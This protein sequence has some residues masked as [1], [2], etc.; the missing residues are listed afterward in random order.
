MLIRT[1]SAEV[2][3]ENLARIFF[4]CHFTV[5]GLRESASAICGVVIHWAMKRTIWRS[6]PVN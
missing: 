4:R 1:I 6:R 5:S 3:A 2:E